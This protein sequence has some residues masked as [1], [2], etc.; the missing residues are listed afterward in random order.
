[1]GK[2][3]TNPFDSFSAKGLNL[4]VSLAGHSPTLTFILPCVPEFMLNILCII[5]KWYSFKF[6]STKVSVLYKHSQN[7]SSPFHTGFLK[8]KYWN[9]CWDYIW[10]NMVMPLLE[11]YFYIPAETLH[12]FTFCIRKMENVTRE[13]R[14][15]YY[16]W[17]D[18]TSVTLENRPVLLNETDCIIDDRIC[19]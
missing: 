10:V 12:M 2:D 5:S 6:I 3:R 8:K 4:W 18:T 19:R 11:I 7:L 17:I 13:K 16:S 9:H 1:M 15:A 14:T